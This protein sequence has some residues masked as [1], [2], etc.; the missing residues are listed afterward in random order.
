MVVLV[1][2]RREVPGPPGANGLH[3]FS[4]RD[5]EPA[6]LLPGTTE[7]GRDKT[8]D[9]EVDRVLRPDLLGDRLRDAGPI[10]SEVVRAVTDMTGCRTSSGL[11]DLEQRH[12]TDFLGRKGTLEA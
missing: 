6:A 12:K 8:L 4:V 3:R 7:G 5:H 9:R 2:G 1:E 10:P 11:S